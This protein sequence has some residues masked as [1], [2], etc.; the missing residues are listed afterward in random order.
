MATIE[1]RK[2]THTVFP[3]MVIA[4]ATPAPAPAYTHA[5]SVEAHLTQHPHALHDLTP[6]ITPFAVS[7]WE[8]ELHAANMYNKYLHVI[9]GI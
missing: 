8:T 6:I 7:Q 3:G 4:D 5:P 2:A 9:N 1:T